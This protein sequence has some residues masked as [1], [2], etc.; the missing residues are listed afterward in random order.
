MC[1]LAIRLFTL[2]F[3]YI[4]N[5]R[6]NRELVFI[7]PLCSASCCAHNEVGVLCQSG[8][9]EPKVRKYCTAETTNKSTALV[10]GTPYR[11]SKTPKPRNQKRMW[12]PFLRSSTP[13][14]LYLYAG[15][16]GGRGRVDFQLAARFT[17][18]KTVEET[19]IHCMKMTQ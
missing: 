8:T 10:I 6:F 12:Y 15:G 7:H 1:L 17:L 13:S 3:R 5:A 11:D 9:T 2:G 14:R 16:K 19:A 4:L 18:G